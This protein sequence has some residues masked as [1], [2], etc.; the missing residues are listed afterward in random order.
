M[1]QIE[2]LQPRVVGDIQR[3]EVVVGGGDVGQQGVLAEVQTFKFVLAVDALRGVGAEQLHELG[4]L[5]QVDVGD[6][7]LGDVQVPH[8]GHGAEVELGDGRELENEVQQLG[9]AGEVDRAEAG[10]VVEVQRHQ[11]GIVRT[12]VGVEVVDDVALENLQ[13]GLGHADFDGRGGRARVVRQ[14]DG[15]ELGVGGEVQTGQL[16]VLEVEDIEVGASAE[17]DLGDV[18]AVGDEDVDLGGVTVDFHLAGLEDAALE[19]RA[20]PRSV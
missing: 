9:A 10:C 2:R 16:V 3:G 12:E 6:A 20:I 4:G 15:G 18:A 8:A 17:V 7:R 19:N 5:R 14:V 1:A 13:V 11:V